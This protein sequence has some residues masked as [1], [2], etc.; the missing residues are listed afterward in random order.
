MDRKYHR[1]V[2]SGDMWEVMAALKEVTGCKISI[3]KLT[4]SVMAWLE[5]LDGKPAPKKKPEFKFSDHFFAKLSM[6]PCFD[7]DVMESRSQ[8]RKTC[9]GFRHK[10]TGERVYLRVDP[11][12]LVEFRMH[13]TGYVIGRRYM[14]PG[15]DRI[16]SPFRWDKVSRLV[17]KYLRKNGIIVKKRQVW[18][19]YKS[20]SDRCHLARKLTLMAL[21]NLFNHRRI[22]REQH[23]EATRQ[24]RAISGFH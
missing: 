8:I 14:L 9:Y 12:S 23:E 19:Y 21:D 18:E 20:I 2:R 5:N 15:I 4:P 3:K 1:V 13:P 6:T 17:G 24:I 22:S 10:R 7:I 16:K 11:G